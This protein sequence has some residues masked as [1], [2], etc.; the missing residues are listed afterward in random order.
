MVKAFQDPEISK[1]CHFENGFQDQ[2]IWFR[3]DV[4]LATLLRAPLSL[5]VSIK[6]FKSNYYIA[7]SCWPGGGVLPARNKLVCML[8]LQCKGALPSSSYQYRVDVCS[9]E[10]QYQVGDFCQR[11]SS[12]TSFIYTLLCQYIA[13]C[14]RSSTPMYYI[15][16]TSTM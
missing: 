13:P 4:L 2:I 7:F 9:M 11:S 8:W 16:R 10:Q 1:K 5:P 12:F 3:V 15:A 6:C 14:Y